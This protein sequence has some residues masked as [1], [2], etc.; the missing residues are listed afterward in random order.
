MAYLDLTQGFISTGPAAA[1]SA[2]NSRF[3]P[4]L[5]R[6][7]R[8]AIHIA[9]SDGIDSLA[10]PERGNRFMRWLFRADQP[11]P[12]ADPRLE[13]LRRYAVL[14]RLRGGAM[15]AGETRR[16]LDAGFARETLNEVDQLVYGAAKEINRAFQS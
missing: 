11:N 14:L 12:L 2:Q 15:P 10:Q 13:A 5:T 3:I 8:L 4:A 1:P 6:L 9:Q 7:E 16:L